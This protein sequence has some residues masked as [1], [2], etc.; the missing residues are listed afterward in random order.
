MTTAAVSGGDAQA[1]LSWTNPGDA[2]LSQ[3]IVL[4]RASTAVL[5]TP[6]EGTSYTVGTALGASSVACVVSTPSTTCTDT[7]LTNG[8]SYHYKLFTKDSNSNYAASGVVPTG[9]PVSPAAPVPDATSFG[10]P[11]ADGA[12]SGD[13]VTVT[14]T[15]FGTVPAGSRAT[16]AGGAGTGCVRFIVGG[17]TTVPDAS[18]SAWTATS[19]TLTL[20]A[21]L[22]SYGGAAAL[23]IVAGSQSDITPLTFYIYPN[24]TGFASFY[25]SNAA[26][27]YA[28]GDTEGLVY[29][30]GDHFGSTQGTASFTGGLGGVAGTVHATLG[31]PCSTG[32]WTDTAICLEVN[33]IISDSAYVGSTTIARAG[34][35]KTA[36]WGATR[37]LPRVT[38]LAPTS[39]PVGTTVAISGNHLC[40]SGTCPVSPNRSTA[41]DRVSFGGTIALDSDFV[42]PPAGS[43][44]VTSATLTTTNPNELLLV[45]IA[46]QNGAS[47]VVVAVSGGGLTWERVGS[48][49]N[50]TAARV[51]VWRAF[52]VSAFSGTITATLSASAK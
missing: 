24:I 31:A 47:Q 15:N 22:A 25:G 50:G 43:V 21:S 48:S 5:D 20:P 49:T 13:T 17:N 7:G 19:I 44:T 12:R 2:D 52:A 42:T 37:I 26:R 51:E 38:A 1:S 16:C 32:G 4:R 36:V 30:V 23:Q 14:G 27:E 10:A 28:A 39:G 29:L 34:D 6:V 33:P 9:S 8:T 35:A 40:E 45:S 41:S 11:L 46:I 18:V 3:T